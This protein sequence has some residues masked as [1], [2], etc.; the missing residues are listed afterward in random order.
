MASKVSSMVFRYDVRAAAVLPAGL[1]PN[2][3]LNLVE[4]AVEPY[5]FQGSARAE[6]G[7]DVI[8]WGASAVVVVGESSP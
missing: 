8:S 3:N 5:Y 1:E 4:R 2:L 7:Y 6:Q